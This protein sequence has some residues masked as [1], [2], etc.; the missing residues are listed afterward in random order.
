MTM[1]SEKIKDKG[2]KKIWIAEKLNIDTRTLN[3]WTKYENLTQVEKFIN[4]VKLLDLPIEDVLEEMFKE[5]KK[6]KN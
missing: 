1:I 6:D 3:C 4:L 2:L 5:I